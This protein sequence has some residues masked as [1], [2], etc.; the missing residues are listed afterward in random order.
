MI[1]ASVAPSPEAIAHFQSGA[2][3]QVARIFYQPLSAS[4]K[5][6]DAPHWLGVTNAHSLIF[7]LASTLLAYR[8]GNSAEG[9]SGA[10]HKF[11]SHK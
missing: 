2:L 10:R 9:H 4:P 1:V 3:D 8:G 5:H 6:A 7:G 11:T